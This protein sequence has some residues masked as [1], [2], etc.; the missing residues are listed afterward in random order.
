MKNRNVFAPWFGAAVASLAF[1]SHALAAGPA[2]WRI[3][4][5]KDRVFAVSEAYPG[6]KFPLRK[7]LGGPVLL[8]FKDS[9]ASKDIGVLIYRAGVD[10]FH[11]AYTVERAIVVFKPAGGFLGQGVW[12]YE[13]VGEAPALDQPVW[14]WSEKGVK[15]SDPVTLEVSEIRW[16]Q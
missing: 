5:D 6:A 8:E 16:A 4:K 14:E 3:L 2:G 13:P 10:A 9:P 7:V 15:I 12:R 1:A 11:N